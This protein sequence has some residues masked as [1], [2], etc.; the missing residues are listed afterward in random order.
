MAKAKKMKSNLG[1]SLTM[2]APSVLVLLIMSTF[3]LIFT[4]IYSFTDY[5]YLSNGAPGFVGFKN[6]VFLFQDKYFRQ[7]IFNTV[8]FTILATFFETVLGVLLAVFINSLNHFKNTVRTLVLVPY[9][10]PPVT[11]SLMWKIMLSPNGGILNKFLSM[12]GLPVYNWFYDIKTAFATIVLIDVWQTTPFVFLL[13]YAQLQSIPK[14][15][16]EAARMDGA[17]VISEFLNVTLPGIKTGV[18]LCI[19][20][21]TID[22]FRLFEKVNILTQGGPA[23]STATITQYLYNYGI[24]SLKFG[25]GSAGSLVMTIMV[26][27]LSAVYVERAIQNK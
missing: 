26:L 14:T 18:F 23:N 7:A 10:L 3:P 24:K 8:L 27:I 2:T 5:Y 16:Y 6:F 19:M 1:F 20:L 15:L 11:A 9:I 17:G 12:M 25:F 4:V 13:V 21:R 22:S